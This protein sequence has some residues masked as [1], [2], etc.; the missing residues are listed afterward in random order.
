MGSILA[1][2]L[3]IFSHD[4]LI[5]LMIWINTE[6][7]WQHC[8]YQPPPPQYILIPMIYNTQKQEVLTLRKL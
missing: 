7:V 8:L 1:P 6:N 2:Q 4:A 3:T 5:L